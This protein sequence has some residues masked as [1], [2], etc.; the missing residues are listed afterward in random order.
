[1]HRITTFVLVFVLLSLCF[2]FLFFLTMYL[3]PFSVTGELNLLL[4][5]R[6]NSITWCIFSLILIHTCAYLRMF[7]N[8]MQVI[9]TTSKQR[10]FTILVMHKNHQKA[11][12]DSEVCKLTY[13]MCIHLCSVRLPLLFVS[14]LMCFSWLDKISIEQTVSHCMF[15]STYYQKS[16]SLSLFAPNSTW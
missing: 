11:L 9:S 6:L 8:Y 4:V 3:V 5:L 2:L 13:H 15:I 7:W 16:T 1:M 14:E 10:N 12:Q